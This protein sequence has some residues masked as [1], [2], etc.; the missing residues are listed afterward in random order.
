VAE[1]KADTGAELA[2]LHGGGVLT[3][4]EY[5]RQKR[6]VLQSVWNAM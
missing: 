5:G 3:D 4:K 2:T 6:S 1:S